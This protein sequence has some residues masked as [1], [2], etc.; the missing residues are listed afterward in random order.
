[1]DIAIKQSY[2]KYSKY[3]HFLIGNAVNGKVDV[4]FFK[5]G[6]IL[7]LTSFIY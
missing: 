7:F 1:M 3:L 5:K 2:L 4:I 6:I